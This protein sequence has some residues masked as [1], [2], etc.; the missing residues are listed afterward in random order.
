MK[1]VD[2]YFR[3]PI[4]WDCVI[5]LL[6]AIGAYK[7][8]HDKVIEIPKNDFILSSVS[9]IANISFSSTGF[10]LTILT[11]LITFKAG[12]RRKDKI[13]N[14]DSAL[15]FFFQTP[16]YGQTTYHLK[17]CI[18][19]LVFLGLTGYV[20]KITTPKSLMDYL[21]YFLIFSLFILALTLMRCLLILNRVLTLQNK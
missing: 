18:K 8:T 3:N 17:N 16:L 19:S 1:I 7:L 20:F 6:L 12:S 15:D 13:E 9:D 2:I 10:I 11:V 14:Y 21:F 4:S 5:S